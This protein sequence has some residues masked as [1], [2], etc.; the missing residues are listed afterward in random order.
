MGSL[1]IPT[2]TEAKVEMVT[3][4]LDPTLKADL[5]E[6]AKQ[7]S[8][9]LGALL[10]E[11]IRERVARKKRQEFEAEAHRQSLEAAAAAREPDSD[12]AQV[13]RELEAELEELADE[14]K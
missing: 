6:V 10:R 7:E 12:E 9:T 2:T 13:M 14:W 5:V 11:L 3:V 4:R 8:K 1:M